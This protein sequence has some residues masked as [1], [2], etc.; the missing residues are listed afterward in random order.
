M[1]RI[2]AEL[3]AEKLKVIYEE[4]S[5]LAQE[6]ADQPRSA[7]LL[8]FV[9]AMSL[10]PGGLGGFVNRIIDQFKDRF[11]P[12]E[13]QNL[14]NERMLIGSEGCLS[15]ARTAL[16]RCLYDLCIVRNKPLRPPWYFKELIPVLYEAMDQYKAN[17][18]SS[19]AQTEVAKFAFHWLRF[20][21]SKK[22]PVQFVGAS[23]F[24]KSTVLEAWCNSQPGLARTVRVPS[25][26]RER[27]FFVAHADA[28]GITYE[29][30]T[31][32][33]KIRDL[34]QFV[35]KHGG[36]FIGYDESHGLF[37][38]T[39]TKSNAKRRLE[40][41]R[42][43]VID[44]RIGCAFFA[45][46]QSYEESLN[47]F[48]KETGYNLDQWF[49]RMPPVQVLPDDLGLEDLLAVAVLKFPTIPRGLL[50]VICSRA[51]RAKGYL[52]SIELTADYALEIAGGSQVTGENVEEALNR[53]LP[54]ARGLVAPDMQPSC[55]RGAEPVQETDH[56][57]SRVTFAV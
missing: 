52:H 7:E 4:N 45:T 6:F 25:A 19:I 48:A 2:P 29:S 24:G 50:R 36:L 34:V 27:D 11:E 56:P 5:D 12:A 57:V 32:T 26:S 23:R 35:L 13:H 28:L 18:L 49:G 21:Q 17:A 30:T 20:A 39:Y 53:I 41:V 1:R 3:V 37:Q 10:A 43:H 51:S 46:P 42:E 16:E 14:F 40:W 15:N 54:G 22:R 44:R 33:G 8:W 31:D 55:T 47:H 38:L 9:Q